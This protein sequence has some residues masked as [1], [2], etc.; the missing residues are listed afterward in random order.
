[1]VGQVTSYHHRA[2]IWGSFTKTVQPTMS[3]SAQA[4]FPGVSIAVHES[5]AVFQELAGGPDAA[6]G[7][8]MTFLAAASLATSDR[9]ATVTWTQPDGAKGVWR[10]PLPFRPPRV[11]Y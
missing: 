7:E 8:A 3:T 6:S 5:M 4:R 9:T 10:Y 1:M 11:K 2:G